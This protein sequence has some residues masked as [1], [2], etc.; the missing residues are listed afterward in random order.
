MRGFDIVNS[1]AVTPK[2][3]GWKKTVLVECVR[4]IFS[5]C[6]RLAF[7]Y[8]AIESPSCIPTG[9][10]ISGPDLTPSADGNPWVSYVCRSNVAMIIKSKV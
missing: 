7:Y 5:C 4:F 9:R 3:V 1:R 8:K 2:K 10:S 6:A